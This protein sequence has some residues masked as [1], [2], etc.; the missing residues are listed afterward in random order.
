MEKTIGP[1][2]CFP[3]QPQTLALQQMPIKNTLMFFRQTQQRPGTT[4]QIPPKSFLIIQ[5]P[6]VSKKALTPMYLWAYY[7]INGQI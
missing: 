4:M 2:R 6:P 1:W 5:L 7:H 3:K